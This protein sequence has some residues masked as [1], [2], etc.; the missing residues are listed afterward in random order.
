MIIL[1]KS[2]KLQAPKAKSLAQT[3]LMPTVFIIATVSLKR[4]MIYIYHHIAPGRA[5]TNP[6][7]RISKFKTSKTAIKILISQ[8]YV[9]V[10]GLSNLDIVWNLDIGIWDF[11]SMMVEVNCFNLAGLSSTLTFPD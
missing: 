7:D 6:N 3:G 5:Q 8:H 11:R 9:W 2:W 4:M 1:L 10:I